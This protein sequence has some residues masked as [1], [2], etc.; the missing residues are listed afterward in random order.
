MDDHEITLRDCLCKWTVSVGAFERYRDLAENRCIQ[1]FVVMDG[2]RFLGL[3]SDREAAL[4]PNRIF[5]DLLTRRP[6]DPLH[7]DDPILSALERLEAEEREFLPLV[8]K[9]DE[10]VGVVS[11]FAIVSALV[12][13]ERR[14]RSHLETLLAQ[15]RHELDHH[16]IAASVFESTSEGIMV[17]DADQRIITVNRAFTETTGWKTEEVVGKTPGILHS[18]RHDEDFYNTMWERLEQTGT[19]EGEV[20]N[21]RKNGEVYPEFLH[22]DAVHDEAGRVKYYAGVFSDT[23]HFREM[24]ER[25]Q[26]LVYYDALT[27]LPNRKLFFDHLEHAIADARAKGSG[28]GLV[29]IDLDGFKEVN[30][31]LGHMIGDRLLQQVART[32]SESVDEGGSVARLGGD[33]FS[34]FFQTDV[35][36]D[37]LVAHAERLANVLNRHFQIDDHRLFVSASLGISRYPA[38]GE[39]A[40]SLL[41]AADNAM[42]KAKSDGKGHYR[43]YS[44]S[45]HTQF[46]QRVRMTGELRQALEREEMEI[47]W[48]PQ[49]DLASGRIIGA[50]AL[51]RWRDAQGHP[52]PPDV[53][54]PLAEQSGLISE[55]GAQVLRLATREIAPILAEF[56]QLAG[57]FRFAVNLSPAQITA[58]T[59][60]QDWSDRTLD[61]IIESLESA[62]LSTCQIEIELTES[63]L[64]DRS[65][66]E[67]ALGRI[68][69]AGIS[70][71]IDDFGTGCSN[72]ATIKQLPVTK[73]K[74]DRSLVIGIVDDPADR[75]IAA[76]VVGMARGLRLGVLAEGVEN[77]EQA[78]LLL[79]LGCDTAQGYLYSPPLSNTNFR[80]YVRDNLAH[81]RH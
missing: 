61:A 2:D 81:A 38:D 4:F 71:A 69:E 32:L 7:E 70:L 65:G 30:D 48:Q 5:A 39:E 21:R 36:E 22:I 10:H 37:A 6:P 33:E 56:P 25:L 34:V 66:I 79:G 60:W 53:F 55:L 63:A 17:T 26:Y 50:E 75:E 80:T 18:G 35:D 59:H 76:A 42:Y 77:H 73:L 44:A 11:R 78:D 20:W 23:T 3:V 46:M 14:L 13:Q 52:V 1:I 8:D 27:G 72:L 54:I 68:G 49:V 9:N 47:A 43:F 64:A 58:G 45:S 41:M 16:R 12:V 15:Y 67:K 19:W 62:D 51:A 40:Q 24:R 74:I 29:F 31:T 28:V 57:D